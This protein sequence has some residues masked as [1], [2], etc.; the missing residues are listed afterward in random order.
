MG[1]WV[2]VAGVGTFRVDDRTAR[3]YDGRWDVFM[4]SHLEAEMFGRIETKVKVVR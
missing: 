3:R 4:R 2:S 1:T